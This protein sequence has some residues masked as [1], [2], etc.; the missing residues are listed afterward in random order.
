MTPENVL[1]RTAGGRPIRNPR[2]KPL[3]S[4]AVMFCGAAGFGLVA[5]MLLHQP[6]PEMHKRIPQVT[7]L[8]LPPPPPPKPEEKPPDPPKVKEE[9]KIEPPRPQEQ[10]QPEQAPPQGPLGVDAQGSGASD[11]FGLVGRPGG[12]DITTIGSG[13]SSLSQNLYGTS[14][15]R[16]L[17]QELARDPKLKA[18][19]YSVE[20]L[21]WIGPDGRVLRNQIVKGS[22]SQDLDA[23]IH[24]GIS[25]A[26]VYR[27][28]MPDNLPQPLRIRLKSSDA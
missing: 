13:G 15:A 4:L 10:P 11:G 6:A 22:G 18:A 7:I 9:V 8:R 14:V 17:A 27:Q 1:A 20:V 24:G 26:G 5:A 25:Q 21:V 23:L 2:R 3:Q 28:A 19:A 12:R 16:F